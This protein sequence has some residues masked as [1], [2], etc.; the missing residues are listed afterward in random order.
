MGELSA[1]PPPCDGETGSRA[2]WRWWTWSGR[3]LRFLAVIGAVV[4]S[5][6]LS[7]S[8]FPYSFYGIWNF[9][10]TN[11]YPEI[12]EVSIPIIETMPIAG[13]FN[14]WD[15]LLLLLVVSLSSVEFDRGRRDSEGFAF[16]TGVFMIVGRVLAMLP[17]VFFSFGFDEACELHGSPCGF[18]YWPL[19]L[20]V[21]CVHLPAILTG[22]AMTRTSKREGSVSWRERAAP[23]A[24]MLLVSCA[25]SWVVWEL[26]VW[27]LIRP[28]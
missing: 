19:P 2:R 1:P 17:G 10:S 5:G 8:I 21:A 28:V 11:A 22:I 18:L 13:P 4:V 23:S 6:V 9:S 26:A 3:L 16:N 24:R 12:G 14:I 27:P 15:P 25:V 20:A 7:W